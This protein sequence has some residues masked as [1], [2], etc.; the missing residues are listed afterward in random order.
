[1]PTYSELE[2]LK[3]KC[4]HEWTSLN[5]QKGCKL[6]GPNGNCIFLP[7]AGR[8]EWS[9]FYIDGKGGEYWTSTPQEEYIFH[10]YNF[11]TNT[12]SGGFGVGWTHRYQG[13]SIRP[14]SD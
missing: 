8:Y 5:G 7:A 12:Y 6:T 1:M 3:S 10:S 2:E 13:L 14:V 4:A 9:T 11:Y